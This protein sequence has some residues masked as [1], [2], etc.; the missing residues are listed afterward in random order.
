MI[1]YK[2]LIIYGISKKDLP[3]K[4]DIIE[5]GQKGMRKLY[6]FYP[7]SEGHWLYIKKGIVTIRGLEQGSIVSYA[8]YFY[9]KTIQDVTIF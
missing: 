5:F 4:G 1:R 3:I 7:S 2:N 9:K 6:A 8:F